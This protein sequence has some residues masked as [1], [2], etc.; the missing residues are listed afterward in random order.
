MPQ[1]EFYCSLI[2]AGVHTNSAQ[3]IKG[4]SHTEDL[5]IASQQNSQVQR[6]EELLFLLLEGR[7]RK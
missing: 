6:D 4:F 7:L 1:H 2:L 3:R 5:G